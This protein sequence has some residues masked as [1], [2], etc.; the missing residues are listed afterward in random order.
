MYNV[1]LKCANSNLTTKLQTF[2]LN[3]AFY[4]FFFANR[5]IIQKKIVKV[6]FIKTILIILKERKL[7]TKK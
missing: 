1:K 6:N 2:Y 4:L 7:W 3:K 5:L